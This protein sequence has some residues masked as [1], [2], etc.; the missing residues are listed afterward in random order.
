MTGKIE[1]ATS[2]TRVVVDLFG[3]FVG[4]KRVFNLED[5]KVRL[6]GKKRVVMKLTL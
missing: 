2:D 4:V 5:R 3:S 6:V 1:L